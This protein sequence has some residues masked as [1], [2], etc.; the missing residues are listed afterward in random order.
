MTDVAWPAA[1]SR[2]VVGHYL[3]LPIWSR[4]LALLGWGSFLWYES[5]LSP[6]PHQAH[7]M[8]RSWLY[9]A[10]H[11]PAFGGVALLA[12]CLVPP[13]ARIGVGIAASLCYGIVDEYHQ[14]FTPGRTSSWTDV[15]SDTVGGAFAL[16]LFSWLVSGSA[17]GRLWSLLLLPCA[18]AA[19]TLANLY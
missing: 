3:R 11:I 9:N 2:W 7:S 16:A 18:L 19:P 5:S 12:A 10:A 13:R 6:K 4:I 8:L 15:L 17:R 1:V 14:S